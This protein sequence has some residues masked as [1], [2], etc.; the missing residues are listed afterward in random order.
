MEWNY[1]RDGPD[2]LAGFGPIGPY[3]PA[4]K[5]EV[6]PVAGDFLVGFMQDHKL[7]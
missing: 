5:S 4:D 1:E 2:P 7:F 6:V 3:N